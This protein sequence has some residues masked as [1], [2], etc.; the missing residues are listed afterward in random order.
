MELGTGPGT[1]LGTELDKAAGLGTEVGTGLG[2]PTL[3]G[4][5]ERGKRYRQLLLLYLVTSFLCWSRKQR[6]RTCL[7]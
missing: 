3:L 5:R 7:K 6:S 4:D 2:E 1:G